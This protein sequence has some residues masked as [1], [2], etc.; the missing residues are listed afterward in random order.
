[1]SSK[2]RLITA[3]L[4]VDGVRQGVF[5]FQTVLT[6]TS[7]LLIELLVSLHLAM[8]NFSTILSASGLPCP[9]LAD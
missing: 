5:I 9:A 8:F 4:G 7:S 1:M 3:W 2:G 6:R